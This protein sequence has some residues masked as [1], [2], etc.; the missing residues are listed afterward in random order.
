M[1]PESDQIN[2]ACKLLDETSQPVNEHRVGSNNW[3]CLYEEGL[4]H[5]TTALPISQA[6]TRKLEFEDEFGR[7]E[8]KRC[9]QQADAP[10]KQDIVE[11][12]SPK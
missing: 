2:E 9:D 1:M 4:H 5:G 10:Q 3:V 11:V 8:N 6:T 12:P 7:P